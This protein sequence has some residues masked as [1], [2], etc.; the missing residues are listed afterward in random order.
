[1][2]R[3]NHKRKTVN[4]KADRR[5][6]AADP[7]YDSRSKTYSV[8]PPDRRDNDMVEHHPVEPLIRFNKGQGGRGR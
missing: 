6:Q 3:H 8:V 4:N 1:M 5:T 2:G 7:N